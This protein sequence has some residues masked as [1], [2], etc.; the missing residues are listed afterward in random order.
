MIKVVIVEDERSAVKRLRSMLESSG[1]P[2]KIVKELDSVE[3]SITF[4]SLEKDYDLIFMDVHLSDGSSFEIFEKIKI[5][6]PIIFVT[7]YD[8]YALPAFK[9]NTVDYLLKPLKLDLVKSALQKF[10]NLYIKTT[11]NS[12]ALSIE[13]EKKWMIKIGSKFTVIKHSEVAYYFTEDKITYLI[14]FDEKKLH[15]DAPLEHIYDRID[16]KKYFH[17]NR[18]YIINRDAIISFNSHTKGRVILKILHLDRGIVVSSI[19]TP[20][21]KK[22]IIT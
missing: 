22:W 4:F 16:Q 9:V 11:Q 13:E 15:I 6:N 2:I 10:E 19:K 18:Q 8:R 12:N 1:F 3:S 14:T 21:F 17:A 7:A 20:E 5:S